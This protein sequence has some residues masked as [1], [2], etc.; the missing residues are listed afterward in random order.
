[1]DNPLTGQESRSI[2]VDHLDRTNGAASDAEHAEIAD[3]AKDADAMLRMIVGSI[4]PDP[5][6]IRRGLDKHQARRSS[7]PG[8]ELN[9][10]LVILSVALVFLVFALDLVFLKM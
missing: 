2:P 7:S 5:D 1:M 10:R 9:M 3:S 6:E 4:S 8:K